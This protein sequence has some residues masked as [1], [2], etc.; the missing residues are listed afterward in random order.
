MA[1]LGLGGPSGLRS[2]FIWAGRE[3]VK[4]KVRNLNAPMSGREQGFEYISR[5]GPQSPVR[6]MCFA[7][8]LEDNAGTL[9]RGFVVVAL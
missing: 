4:V 7:S 2:F 3:N 9:V 8:R 5:F 1:V 6:C